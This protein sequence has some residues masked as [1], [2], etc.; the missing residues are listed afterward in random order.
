MN[1]PTWK[2]SAS[3][4]S[5]TT[6]WMLCSLSV[7]LSLTCASYPT[8]RLLPASPT[9]TPP[10]SP[11]ALPSDSPIF[12]EDFNGQLA[13]AWRWQN[14]DASHY[15]LNEDGWLE[16]TGGDESILAGGQQTNLLWITLPEGEIEISIHLKSQPLFDF[17][18]AGLLLY[19]DSGNYVSLARGHCTQC[20]L[21][22]NGIFLEYSFDGQHEKYSIPFNGADLYLMLMIE[23]GVV[24]A[25]YAVDADQ[26]QHVASVENGIR[27]ERAAL[28]VTNDS[29]WDN[30]YDVVG[31]FDYLEIRLPTQSAPT[32]TPNGFQQAGIF[33][34][35]QRIL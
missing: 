27:F 35:Q 33:R 24:S 22:G 7:F 11:S 26:W 15:K 29:A 4:T 30:G 1:D 18:R 10:D 28:S 31:K 2:K 5:V 25:F 16:I 14:E 23:Q 21:G 3:S 8:G 34:G 12:H 6:L 32:P 20:V 17:Q 13:P 9:A 19:R